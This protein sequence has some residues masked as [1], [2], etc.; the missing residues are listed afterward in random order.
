MP[1]PISGADALSGRP[2][3]R[4]G[5]FGLVAAPS[6][7]IAQGLFGWWMGARICAPSS[8]LEVRAVLGAAGVVAMIIASLGLA[9]SLRE[10]RAGGTAHPSH[11]ES[12][13]LLAFG[14]V[15]VSAAFCLGILWAMLSAA[16]IDVC[17]AM[18]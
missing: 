2:P 3:S 6:A 11:G 10:Y 18:R 13:A 16:F 1:F 9:A 7:W 8:I 17:G 14:G 4:P 12:R 5:W 15:F